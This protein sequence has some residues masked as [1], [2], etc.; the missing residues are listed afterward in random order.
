VAYFGEE[1]HNLQPLFLAAHPAEH[2]ILGQVA[3]LSSPLV[4]YWG[5]DI[6]QAFVVSIV[7]PVKR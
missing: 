5:L 4:V 6:A 2:L 1:A 7:S 3:V